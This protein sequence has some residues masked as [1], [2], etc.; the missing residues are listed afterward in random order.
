MIFVWLLT[1]FVATALLFVVF[2]LLLLMI[3]YAVAPI[4]LD[5]LLLLLF[6]SHCHINFQ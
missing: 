5:W 2:L 4:G 6:S 3:L 1:V